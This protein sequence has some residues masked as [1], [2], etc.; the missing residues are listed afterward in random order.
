MSATEDAEVSTFVLCRRAHLRWGKLVASCGQVHAFALTCR[1]SDI[2]LEYADALNPCLAAGKMLICCKDAACA[3]HSTAYI[4]EY[5][6][7]WCVHLL[8]RVGV[9]RH[10]FEALPV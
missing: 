4:K 10:S 2:I 9:A 7:R 1:W 3:C 6:S 8:T 5:G